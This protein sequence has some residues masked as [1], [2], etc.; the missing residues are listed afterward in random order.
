M[1]SFF[2]VSSL[3]S[4]PQFVTESHGGGGK[5]ANGGKEPERNANTCMRPVPPLSP[6]CRQ[7]KRGDV[8]LHGIRLEKKDIRRKDEDQK[9]ADRET[10]HS[11]EGR[12][13]PRGKKREMACGQKGKWQ[14]RWGAEKSQFCTNE[15]ARSTENAN[16]PLQ[17]IVRD[18]RK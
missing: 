9:R 1:A 5:C 4:G 14:G 12:E 2:E 3:G 11:T 15:I 10:L 18:L 8:N 13:K 6:G 7:L 17:R 16:A